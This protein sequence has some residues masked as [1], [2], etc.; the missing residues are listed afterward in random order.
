MT[1][2]SDCTSASSHGSNANRKIERG[3]SAFADDHR[4]HEFNGDVLR[5]RGVRTTPKSEQPAATKKAFR[6]FAASFGQAQRF[7]GEE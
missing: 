5:V 1:M 3:Q 7:R 2:S 4:M 6:H